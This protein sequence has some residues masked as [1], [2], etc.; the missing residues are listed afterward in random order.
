MKIIGDSPTNSLWVISS[1]RNMTWG[2]SWESFLAV[3]RSNLK[4]WT[5]ILEEKGNYRCPSEGCRVSSSMR[6][7]VEAVSGNVWTVINL[8]ES[9]YTR[10]VEMNPQLG[11][12][13]H[14]V[15]GESQ[16][17]S[18]IARQIHSFRNSAVKDKFALGAPRWSAGDRVMRER[19]LCRCRIYT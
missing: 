3:P 1:A 18:P 19:W 8:E 7:S 11:S 15:A 6:S 10:R 12:Q 14:F 13:F 4:I 9:E 2:V 17:Q 16:L 5:S